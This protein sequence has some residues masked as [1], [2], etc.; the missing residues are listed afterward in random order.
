MTYSLEANEIKALERLVSDKLQNPSSTDCKYFLFLIERAIIVN[1][2]NTHKFSREMLGD[3]L[4]HLQIKLG[5]CQRSMIKADENRRRQNKSPMVIHP[6]NKPLHI[7]KIDNKAGFLEDDEK[8]HYYQ[9]ILNKKPWIIQPRTKAEFKDSILTVL[10]NSWLTPKE[11]QDRLSIRLDLK[12]A[13]VTIYTHLTDLVAQDKIESKR[14][15]DDK[16]KVVYHVI[17]DSKL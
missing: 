6:L 8:P 11:V 9:T 7:D 1:N 13:Y 17:T 3:I 10:E 16:R 15:L 4:K 14:K 2:K 5:A 12:R